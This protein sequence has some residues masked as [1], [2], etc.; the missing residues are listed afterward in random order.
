MPTHK[1]LS[2]CMTVF[3]W[4]LNINIKLLP[5]YMRYCDPLCRIHVQLPYTVTDCN[6]LKKCVICQRNSL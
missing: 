4:A 5:R 3:V 2:C 1:V 6:Y